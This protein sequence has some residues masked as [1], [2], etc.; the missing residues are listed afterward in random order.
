MHNA[1]PAHLILL[2]PII[3]IIQ[4]VSKRTLQMLLC[5]EL[6]KRLHLKAYKLAIVQ[7]PTDADKVVCKEFC[8]QMFH[9]I[10][11]ARD[12]T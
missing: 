2:D 8:M 12:A 1:D 7:H 11:Y 4:D 3:L 10:S 9:A 6:Q 5:G